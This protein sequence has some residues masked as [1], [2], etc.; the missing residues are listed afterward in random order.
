MGTPAHLR[1]PRFCKKYIYETDAGTCRA[2]ALEGNRRAKTLGTLLSSAPRWLSVLVVIA[3][4]LPVPLEQELR[5]RLGQRGQNGGDHGEA[6][7]L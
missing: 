7:V 6:A 1:R 2:A 4:V 5:Q 3:A